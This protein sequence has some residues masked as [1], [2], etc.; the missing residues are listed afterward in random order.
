MTILLEIDVEPLQFVEWL[1]S[2][3]CKMF[4]AE[5][6]AQHE[7]SYKLFQ[8]LGSESTARYFHTQHPENLVPLDLEICCNYSHP[9]EDVSVEDKLAALHIRIR[10]KRGMTAIRIDWHIPEIDHVGHLLRQIVE[11]WSEVQEQIAANDEFLAML[12]A[13]AS[14][15]E[16]D[17]WKDL[18]LVK[19]H[20][21]A[22]TIEPTENKP[23]TEGQP[24]EKIPNHKWDRQALELWH[25][26]H[27][28][29]EIGMRVE[30]EGKT[31]LNRLSVLRRQFGTDIVP[32]ADQLR[33]LKLR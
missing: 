27:T 4:Y 24:W 20:L 25:Q 23:P 17:K 8:T 19:R 32:T 26:G 6:S 5:F 31:V 7:G 21:D 30:T 28:C 14:R 12:E 3:L 11:E 2:P 10:D 33:K 13:T 15:D 9:R 18:Y 1:R 22:Y 16:W 29:S